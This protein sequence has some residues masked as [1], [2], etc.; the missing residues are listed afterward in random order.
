MISGFLFSI[1]NS[2]KILLAV[3]G[4]ASMYPEVGVDNVS[5]YQDNNSVFVQF[6]TVSI[7]NSSIIQ[8]VDSGITVNFTYSVTTTV[9]GQTVYTNNYLEQ[10]T[11]EKSRY[12]VNR[13]KLLTLSELGKRMS[14][15]E[16]KIYGTAHY[17]GM[18][19]V[20]TVIEFGLNCRETPELLKLWG[21][22]PKII[23]NYT[24]GL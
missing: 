12:R 21:N 3:I 5:I 8:I 2:L 17:K 4:L 11:A 14:H 20:K 7:L 24:R 22:K 15:H 10:V 23:I 1:G 19:K 9:K 13:G 18:R 6:D 16:F